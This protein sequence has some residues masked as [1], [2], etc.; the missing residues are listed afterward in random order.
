MLEPDGQLIREYNDTQDGR[1]FTV[2]VQRHV[3]LVYATALRQLG[4]HGLAE[5]VTQNVFIALAQ[6][7]GRLGRHPTLAGWLH[8]TTL[9]KSRE[10]LRAELRRWRRE[11]TAVNL[12]AARTE[13]ESVWAGVVPL[14]DEALLELRE[15][16]RLAVIMHFMEG[17]SFGEVGSTL[18]VGEDAARKRVHRCLEQLTGFFRRRGFAV[19]AL[20]AGAPLFGLSPPAAPAGLAACA[21]SAGLAAGQTATG[22]STLTLIQGAMKIM[23]W[24]KAKTAVIVGAT[25]LLAAGTTTTLVMQHPHPPPAQALPAGQND[26]P[27]D[28]WAFAGYA[29]PPAALIS[30]MW[31]SIC[32]SNRYI[33]ET[34][35]TPAQQKVYR[36][37]IQMNRLV[38]Q[39]HSA[40]ATV[41]ETFKRASDEWQNGGIRILDQQAVD[42]DLVLLHL[43][44]RKLPD[45]VEVYLRMKKLG[46]EWKYDG[47]ERKSPAPASP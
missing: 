11:Q 8:R 1:A 30:Y 9:N 41:A 13:G 39:P 31:A 42:G 20:A 16:D 23:A 2:L 7:A 19:P 32:Q 36:Q 10:R 22:G 29:D 5:E 21:T 33:F 46:N 26:F 15:A 27:R 18:G 25:I 45:N 24:T 38:P 12:A 28:S 6:S 40:A 35:L 47:F 3:H 43:Q 17:R 4:D 44:A 34:S 14:L 37:M